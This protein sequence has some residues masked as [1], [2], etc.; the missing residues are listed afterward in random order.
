VPVAAKSSIIMAQQQFCLKWNN[1]QSNMS[2][3][4][5][6][7]LMNENL[8]D[9]TIACEGASLKAHK[10]ILAC[11][12]PFFQTLFLTN[13]CKHPIVILKDVRYID[14]KAIIDFMYRGEVNVSQDQLSALLKTA[15]MLKVKGLAEVTEKQARGQPQLQ[16]ALYGATPGTGR[17]RRKRNNKKK[18]HEDGETGHSDTDDENTVPS[19]KRQMD[20][21]SPGQRLGAHR[22]MQSQVGMDKENSTTEQIEPS[23]ILEQSM[24]TAEVGGSENGQDNVIMASDVQTLGDEETIRSHVLFEDGTLGT[25]SADGTLLTLPGTSTSGAQVSSAA[26]KLVMTD[27]QKKI[28][29]DYLNKPVGEFDV[30]IDDWK[31][32][33]V[34]NYFGELAHKNALTGDVVVLDEERHYCLQCIVDGQTANAQQ[35]F[36]K[37]CVCFLSKGTA[38]GNHKNHLRHRHNIIDEKAPVAGKKGVATRSSKR[39]PKDLQ[40]IAISMD[41]TAEDKA[42]AES[43]AASEDAMEDEQE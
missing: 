38:T 33:T 36:E 6:S 2:E 42:A 18:V 11:C 3:V 28:L 10:I 29:K 23:R 41:D 4:C 8:V 30:V 27:S 20:T 17:K 13:P 32:S 12:S 14:L 43:V 34:W 39:R 1:Y 9:V 24:A 35:S 16:Q 26:R 5:Q 40:I 22:L 19:A 7:L 37:A 25:A 31:K 15:E 21:R